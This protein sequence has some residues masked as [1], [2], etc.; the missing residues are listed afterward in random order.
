MKNLKK[1]WKQS[2]L[3][4]VLFL[5]GNAEAQVPTQK[6]S[7][8][9]I[10]G[11]VVGN[12]DNA[13]L[14][15][16]T[17]TVKGIDGSVVGKTITANDGSFS[18]KVKNLS[19]IS[20]SIAYLG[21]KDY[22]S[23]NLKIGNMDL[24]LGRISIEEKSTSI[25]GITITAIRKKPLI[26]S[27]KDRIIYNAASDISNKSGNAAD[28]LRKAPML[29]VGAEGDLKL[30]GNSNIKVLIN[31]VPSRI[32]AKNL[33][34]ALKMIPASSILSVEVMTNPSAKYEAE[35]AAGVVNIITRKK[36]KGTSG[37]LDLT[38]GNLEHT[39]N[40][41]LN[42]SSGKFD[43][44]AMGNYSEEREKTASLLERINL[45]NGKQTGSLQQQSD[46]LQTNKGGSANLSARYKI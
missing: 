27:G 44:T 9:N 13:T 11:T 19:T 33:K 20:I 2:I 25:Q 24:D 30:R 29:I 39:G 23:G 7:T 15:G 26:E 36:L 18:V 40:I 10:K 22:H 5:S 28:V 34:E 12:T 45:E 42:A 4:L 8:V 6:K 38:G 3:F 46:L 1:F 41:V 21:F 37:V 35:G 16:S 43:F 31:G 32:M 14:P 17:V